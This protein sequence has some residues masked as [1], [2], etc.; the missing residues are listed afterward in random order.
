M[1]PQHLSRPGRFVHTLAVAAVA[2]GACV[3]RAGATVSVDGPQFVPPD[4]A[5]QFRVWLR[6]R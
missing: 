4:P 6:W 3:T 5:A 2:L 1:T